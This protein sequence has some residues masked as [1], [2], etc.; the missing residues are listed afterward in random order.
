VCDTEPDALGDSERADEKREPGNTADEQLE[1]VEK[2]GE[3]VDGVLDR[4]DRGGLAVTFQLRGD[5][6]VSK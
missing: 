4:L 3:L 5:R 6:L 1:L 2:V